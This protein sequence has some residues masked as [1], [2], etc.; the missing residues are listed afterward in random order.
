VKF[1]GGAVQHHNHSMPKH[2]LFVNITSCLIRDGQFANSG[3]RTWSSF[4]HYCKCNWL[5]C[6][7]TLEVNN[8]ISLNIID[9]Y[10]KLIMRFVNRIWLNVPFQSTWNTNISTIWKCVCVCVVIYNF[11]S[12]IRFFFNDPCMF[13]IGFGFVAPKYMVDVCNVDL[14]VVCVVS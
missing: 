7:L 14:Y 9:V 6:T 10:C 12:K 1:G 11:R 3:C 2:Y 5:F 13:I 4:S 8:F